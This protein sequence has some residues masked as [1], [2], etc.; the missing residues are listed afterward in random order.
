MPIITCINI[1]TIF[2]WIKALAQLEK[3]E[4]Y[5]IVYQSL[6]PDSPSLKILFLS[7]GRIIPI[8]NRNLMY[9]MSKEAELIFQLFGEYQ[10]FEDAKGIRRV[11]AVEWA[12]KNFEKVVPD[13]KFDQPFETVLLKVG[14]STFIGLG[15]YSGILGIFRSL[16]SNNDN[17]IESLKVT[18]LNIIKDVLTYTNIGYHNSLNSNIHTIE[19]LKFARVDDSGNIYIFPAD[20]DDLLFE[21]E[22][23][24]YEQ[25]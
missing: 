23:N 6:F 13:I 25:L 4:F 17:K 7:L 24:I 8:T 20:V 15:L 18:I 14:W 22:E 19:N 2:N 11:K 1:S 5:F 10:S 12:G 21:I 16:P 9:P 3:I